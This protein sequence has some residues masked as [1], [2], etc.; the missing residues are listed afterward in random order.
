[1]QNFVVESF[2]VVRAKRDLYAEFDQH[3]KPWDPAADAREVAARMVN[4]PAFPAGMAQI[5]KAMNWEPRRLNAAASYL[6]RRRLVHFLDSVACHPFAVFRMG[7]T[8]DTRRF[9]K[10][11][12]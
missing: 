9:V 6:A 8:A 10:G 11:R 7:A 5:A 12:P 4:D 1:M 3:W 2:G